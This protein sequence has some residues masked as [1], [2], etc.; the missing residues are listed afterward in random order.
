MFAGMEH[1]ARAWKLLFSLPV[2]RYYSYI[3]KIIM[4]LACLLVS[5]TLAYIGLIL[6]GNI[7]VLG[8][9]YWSLVAQQIYFPFFSA[10]PIIAMQL[11]LAMTVRNQA[12]PLTIGIIGAMLSLFLAYSPN[13]IFH[14]LPWAYI[15]LASPVNKTG[16]EQWVWIGILLG[17]FLFLAG[18]IHFSKRELK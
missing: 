5:T 11:W 15:P 9:T 16:F 8:E 2:A 3:S 12:V 14:F 1:D 18:G 4:I 10:L 17:V 13:R 6:I 7:F